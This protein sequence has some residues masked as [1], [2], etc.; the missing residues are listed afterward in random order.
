[1]QQQKWD[2]S[3]PKV[4]LRFLR[5][6]CSPELI[7]D[8]EGDL[9]ELFE[10]RAE[11]SLKTAR[12][13]FL[14]DILLLFRP[15]IIRNI[16]F[17]QTRSNMLY[18]HIIIAIR[19]ALKY[20]GY[21][22][23]NLLGLVVGLASSIT[24]FTWVQDEISMDT[25][26]ENDIYQIRRNMYQ[27]SGEIQTTGT[28][29]Q[30]LV[31][32]LETEYPEIDKVTIVS[33][34]ED[35]LFRHDTE[36]TYEKGM[37]ASNDFFEVFSFKFLVGNSETSLDEMYSVV[38]SRNLAE[39]YFGSVED[40]L[41]ESFMVDERQEFVVTGVVED[42]RTKSAFKFD[43]IIPAEEFM[44]RN[45]WVES[46][47]NGGFAMYFSLNE[48]GNISEINKRIEQEVNT[49]TNDEADERLF[50]QPLKDKYLYSEFKNGVVAGGRIQYVRILV[51]IAIFLL[52]MA[53]INFMNLATARSSRR[54]KEVGVRKVLGAQ[55]GSLSQQFFIESF[56]LSFVSILLALLVVMLIFPYF[57]QLTGKE[58]TI[59][60]TD[61]NI[62]FPIIGITVVVGLL[63]G[64]YPAFLL[65]SLKI[66]DSLKGIVSSS[67][68]N[69]L[70][71]N[72]LVVFQF[73]LAILL[74]VGT[75]IVTGQTDYILNKN[76]GL[77]KENLIHL[78]VSRELEGKEETYRNQL[79]SIPQIQDV[80]FTSGNP[81]SYGRST[82]NTTWDGKHPDEV[83]EMNI[84]LTEPH[85][86][87]TMGMEILKGRGFSEKLVT[88]TSNF[89]INEVAAK[90]IGYENPVDQR[91]SVWGVEGRIIGVVKNFH[92]SSLYDPIEPMIISYLPNSPNTVF[93]RVKND[94]PT[95]LAEIEKITKKLSPTYPFRYEFLDQ[96]YAASYNSEM[97]VG[98]M[99]RIFAFVSIFISCLG[100]FGL[101]S[102]TADQRAKE[103]GI[104]KVNGANSWGLVY[105]LS[106]NYTRLILIAFVIASPI[107]YY[108]AQE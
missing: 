88:D 74:I 79:L 57:N 84:M 48:A 95:A 97:I 31:E 81:I 6:F 53:C 69:S 5:W 1:M 16:S 26:H 8:V 12:R 91:L 32:V 20:K 44:A 101:S 56:L 28:V 72:G 60:F 98:K 83:V 13:M 47:Y 54:T 61:L 55:K 65:S 78:D 2:I 103:I 33:W 59:S 19:H 86:F 46:W 27:A 89:V 67:K 96:E 15:G 51:G 99:V 58:L 30:P 10:E 23:I 87:N 39:R 90:L 9:C 80:T 22:A 108:M 37:Y 18:N 94:I 3:P 107:A 75:F 62:L 85:F 50:T 29:P 52:I 21:T 77:D 68:F 71:R 40:A 73:A 7:E 25:H 63:S 92:M 42:K 93:I 100:L 4:P 11:K 43:W 17:Y 24:I 34:V 49:H 36:S 105:L 14:W 76:L 106:K 102:Y 82:S 41:G 38:L 35:I 66:I 104:R 64:S 45:N 70:F